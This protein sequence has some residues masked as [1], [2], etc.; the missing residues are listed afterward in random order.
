M[1]YLEASES[2]FVLDND[3]A[4][5][6]ALVQHLQQALRCLPLADET[7]R[8]RVGVALEEALTN[9]CYHGNLE[10]G[11]TLGNKAD[12]RAYEE[13]AAQRR[14][15]APYGDR[16][17]YVTAKISRTEAVFVVRDDGPGF[18]VARVAAA[19]GVAE[20]ERGA[21]RGIVLMD[22]IMDDV[23]Y[24]ARGNEVTLVKRRAPEP[25]AGTEEAP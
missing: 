20:A 5:I 23:T 15:E 2:T 4:L 3:P 1:H 21:G 8:L 12:R 10:V 14:W 16:Q 7:E 24:N 19:D 17:I 25:A 13:L 22:S 11:A 6:Q 9:A 18:D